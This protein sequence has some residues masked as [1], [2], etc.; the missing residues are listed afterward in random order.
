MLRD[1][2]MALSRKICTV[3]LER[4]VTARRGIGTAIGAEAMI[5]LFDI[6]GLSADEARGRDRNNRG[7]LRPHTA[8]ESNRPDF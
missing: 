6:P 2:P 1:L 5:A 4:L 8:S 3:A 7:Y